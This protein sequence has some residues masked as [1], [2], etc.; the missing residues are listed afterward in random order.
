[1]G[2]R[3]FDIA[4]A[5]DNPYAGTALINTTYLS[6]NNLL[7]TDGDPQSV[8]FP[9]FTPGFGSGFIREVTNFL[10]S[11]FPSPFSK[12]FIPLVDKE[13]EFPQ[14]WFGLASRHGRLDRLHERGQLPVRQPTTSRCR[15]SG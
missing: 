11:W 8:G 9:D 5:I 12:L 13:R 4:H 2:I 3:K 14:H 15:R 6:L 7:G 10:P 1:M